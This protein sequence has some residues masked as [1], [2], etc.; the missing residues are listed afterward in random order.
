MK[1]VLIYGA[2]GHGSVVLDCLERSK[3]YRVVGF[4]DSFIKK[5]TKKFG[6]EVLGTAYEL[7]FIIEEFAI[8]GGIIAVGD[9]WIREKIAKRIW[10]IIPGFTFISVIHPTATIGKNVRL[11]SGTVIMPGVIIDANARIGDHCILNTRASL[12]HDG[13]MASF[14]SLAPGVCTGGNLSLGHGSA[15]C[16]GCKVIENIRI[17]SASVIGAGSLVLKN[18]PDRVLAFGN[19]AE[20]VRSRTEGEPYLGK[21]KFSQPALLS[22][23]TTGS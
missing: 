7:P 14:S 4:V 10:E 17:G 18:I 21:R 2:S 20:V 16:L 19:P 13:V 6:Y 22:I 1:N 11:G 23:G 15:V 12:G 3:E 9:N 5:G 8:D